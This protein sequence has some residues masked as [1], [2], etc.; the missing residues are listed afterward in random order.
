MERVVMVMIAGQL[1]GGCGTFLVLPEGMWWECSG[2]K[3]PLCSRCRE[4]TCR[5]GRK[6]RHPRPPRRPKL[7]LERGKT[8][9]HGHIQKTIAQFWGGA[10]V[11]IGIGARRGNEIFIGAY[12]SRGKMYKDMKPARGKFEGVK[13]FYHSYVGPI[14]RIYWKEAMKSSQTFNW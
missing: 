1:C 2:C 12:L 3:K 10:W 14:P 9:K 8:Y 11:I 5:G 4:T 6:S 13:T 7:P